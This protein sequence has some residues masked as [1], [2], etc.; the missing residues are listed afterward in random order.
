M[1][2]NGALNGPLSGSCAG[3]MGV[4]APGVNVSVQIRLPKPPDA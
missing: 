4:A 3:V 1:S 2:M